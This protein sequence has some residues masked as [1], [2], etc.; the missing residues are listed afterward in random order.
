MDRS[1]I[2]YN[3]ASV[4]RLHQSS[5]IPHIDLPVASPLDITRPR[6]NDPHVV[7]RALQIARDA[8]TN[9]PQSADHTYQC[10][11]NQQLRTLTPCPSDMV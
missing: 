4:Q 10:H 2:D 6:V 3:L 1:E 7:P 11:N 8:P 5:V 9:K